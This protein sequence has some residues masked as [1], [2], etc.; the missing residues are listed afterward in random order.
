MTAA[1]TTGGAAIAD[2]IGRDFQEGAAV[3]SMPAGNANAPHLPA[4]GAMRG[5]AALYVVAYHVTYLPKVRLAIADGLLPFVTAGYSGVPLFFMIS[6][7]TLCHTMRGRSES[8]PTLRFYARRAIRILPLFYFLLLVTLA[9][10]YLLLHGRASLAMLLTNVFVVFNL[11]PGK[12]KGIVPASWSVGVE[13]LFYLLFP[14]LFRWVTNMKRAIGFFVATLALSALFSLAGQRLLHPQ[15]LRDDFLEYSLVRSLPCFAIGMIVYR[16]YRATL[17]QGLP[18]RGAYALVVAAAI[19]FVLI[20]EQ[21]SLDAKVAYAAVYAVLVVG[22]LFSNPS[23]LVNK[24]TERLGDMS[25]S[26][27]LWHPLVLVFALPFF[28][29]FYAHLPATVAWLACFGATLAALIPIAYVS[30]RFIEEPS[31][32]A[33]MRLLRRWA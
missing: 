20:A 19:S 28:P 14:A 33:G 31:R 30:Y 4:I 7:F 1:R 2:S 12:E 13:V 8:H 22:L 5:I 15:A 9:R 6:A 24:A 25:Y 10:K 11:V 32:R 29:K 3:G 27:Y 16:V 21:R 18:R 26:L 23:V 17:S